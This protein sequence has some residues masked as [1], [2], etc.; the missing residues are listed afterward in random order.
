MRNAH[1]PQVLT[2]WSVLLLAGVCVG[3][4][5]RCGPLKREDAPTKR[6]LSLKHRRTVKL[7]AGTHRPEL[8]VTPRGETLVVVV[9]PAGGPGPKGP[10]KHQTHRLD[11]RLEP[12]G[13]PWAATRVT[14]QYGE[15]AD[16]RA[17]LV[18]GELVVVYQTLRWKRGHPP[19]GAGPAEG[20]AL[21]Q[22]LMLAR[23]TPSGQELSR[24]AIIERNTNFARDNFP[25]FCIL[26]YGGRLLVSTGSKDGAVKIREVDLRARVMATHA[27]EASTSGIPG[28]L[29]NSML[30]RG[31]GL[32]MVSSAGEGNPAT[33]ALVAL[34]SNFGARQL[35][36][37]SH[38]ARDRRF[39]TGSLEVN[40]FT[41]V[42]YI[43]LPRGTRPHHRSNHYVPHLLVLDRALKVVADIR[44]GAGQGYSHVHP[45]L[46]RAGSRLLVAWSRRVGGG[47][48][49]PRVLVEEYDL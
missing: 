24:A 36:A 16:H 23:F 21:D 14:A 4:A 49:A 22:S 38:S 17:V 48:G 3:C 41:L 29:G 37:F 2:G 27:F 39:P 11:A 40:G 9:Q 44:V 30:R 18:N 34:D 28:V 25:D 47:G 20:H 32:A 5:E 7:P 43:S 1:W 12:V 26:W 31:K 8:L 42:T 19:E 6:G 46:A 35:A 13:R 15:P 10:I 45:V 33:L